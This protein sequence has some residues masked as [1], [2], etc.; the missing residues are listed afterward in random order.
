MKKVIFFSGLAVLFI[1]LSGCGGG[2]QTT[3]MDELAA[4]GNY[5]YQNKE[6]GFSLTLPPEFIYYQTQR[7]SNDG[8]TDIEFFVPT[9]D[10]RFHSLVAG[11]ARAIVVRVY[12]KGAAVD[13]DEKQGWRK[14]GE[15]DG[16]VYVLWLW[17]TQPNDWQKKWNED[18]SKK[19][20]SGFELL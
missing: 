12:D 16:C 14:A 13:I 19:I 1:F 18:M 6:L 17:S 11:Y 4:D 7:K 15:K 10:R 20:V 8:Y 5:H 3:L 9:N 2:K